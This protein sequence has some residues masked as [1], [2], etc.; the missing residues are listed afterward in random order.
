MLGFRYEPLP[1]AE[2]WTR[3]LVLEHGGRD[4]PLRATIQNSSLDQES[5]FDAISYCWGDAQKPKA[6][7]LHRG[8]VDYSFAITESL[9]LALRRFRSSSEDRNLWSDAVCINQSDNEE[10]G[11]QVR[12]MGWI[13]ARA[14]KVLIYL[15]EPDETTS[16]ALKLINKIHTAIVKSPNDDK[17]PSRQWITDN[18]LPLPNARESWKWNPLRDFF[19]RP[20]FRRKWII[21]ECAL[22]REPILHLGDWEKDWDY[23][24]VVLRAISEKSL[25]IVDYTESTNLEEADSLQQGIVQSSNLAYLRGILLNNTKPHLMWL[26]SIFEASRA[27]DARDHIFALLS[28]ASDAS[29]EVLNPRYD[30]T[31]LQTCLTCAKHFLQSQGNLE[32][33]YRAGLRGQ[34]LL[35][36]SWVPDWYGGHEGAGFEV[37][38]GIWDPLLRPGLYNIAHGTRPNF[39]ETREETVIGLRGVRIDVVRELANDGLRSTRTIL[40][41]DA[42]IAQKRRHLEQSD[43]I[44]SGLS[45]YPTCGEEILAD[46]QWRTLVCNVTRDL[47]KAPESYRISFEAYRRFVLTGQEHQRTEDDIKLLQPFRRAA[48]YHNGDKIFGLTDSGYVG[49]FPQLAKAGDVV[50]VFDG[51]E[52]P[53]VLRSSGTANDSDYELVGQCYIHGRME[54]GELDLNDPRFVRQDFFLGRAFLQNIKDPRCYEQAVRAMRNFRC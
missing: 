27:S 13:Y 49:M 36:P 15:G 29:N 2:T 18:R 4:D 52:F 3:I 31:V 50:A 44:I 10:K 20:W 38:N 35:A 6:I 33:L 42:I 46:I 19:R 40:D 22:A 23:M 32:V 54:A 11:H 9:Y 45:T 14:R 25:G 37:N 12:L 1:S 48:D 26:L 16:K 21:Q 41:K 24:A 34:R 28:L 7:S 5:E 17:R 43:R 53:F 8:D 47:Q 39:V 51:G 30:R